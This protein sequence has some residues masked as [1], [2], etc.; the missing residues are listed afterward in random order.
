MTAA[1]PSST[2]DQGA[3]AASPGTLRRAFSDLRKRR[4]AFA[5]LVTFAMLLFLSV[6]ADFWSSSFPIVGRCHGEFYVLANVTQPKALAG[7][8]PIERRACAGS[9]LFA[10]VKFDADETSARPLAMPF[11]EP[12]H[13]FGTDQEGRDVFAVIVYGARI[14]FA[15]ALGCAALSVALGAAV[16]ALAG[17]F[18]RDIWNMEQNALHNLVANCVYRTKRGH[19]LLEDH[20]DLFAADRTKLVALGWQVG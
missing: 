9:A 11:A 1:P 18:A 15:F 12:G 8:S 6:F 10:P 13:P 3:R 14:V 20:A 19:W 2:L 4:L 5:S 16:G 17:F 7:L